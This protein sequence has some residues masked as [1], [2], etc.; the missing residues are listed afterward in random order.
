[1]QVTKPHILDL[2][3]G[4]QSNPALKLYVFNGRYDGSV[5]SPLYQDIKL[6]SQWP[7]HLLTFTFLPFS[8]HEYQTNPE[9]EQ[10]VLG[11]EN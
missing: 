11:D 1:V 4:L 7:A 10:L 3:R 5:P 6:L 2:I 9:V 8:G